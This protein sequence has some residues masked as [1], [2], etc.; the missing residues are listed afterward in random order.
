MR[1]IYRSLTINTNVSKR[2]VVESDGLCV[3]KCLS[4]EVQLE[5]HFIL[6]Q[7]SPSDPLLKFSYE[8]MP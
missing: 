3:M 8:N 4:G 2:H 1:L 7:S 6:A 5:T